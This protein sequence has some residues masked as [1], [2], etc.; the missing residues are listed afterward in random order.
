LEALSKLNRLSAIGATS[1]KEY[2]E[3]DT[4]VKSNNINSKNKKIIDELLA[5]E[6]KYPQYRIISLSKVVELM[7]KYNLCLGVLSKYEETIPEVNQ[8]NIYDYIKLNVPKVS[9][10]SEENLGRILMGGTGDL[11][12]GLL[13]VAPKKFFSKDLVEQNG[14]MLGK[15]DKP[16]FSFKVD[17]TLK[18]TDPIVLSQLRIEHYESTEPYFHIV[19][20]WDVEANDPNVSK[21]I[22]VQAGKN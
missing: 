6:A 22:P 9:K 14:F 11:G 5:F 2:H 12:E 16:K 15:L 3:A 8:N 21:H 18:P 13:M 4:I 7:G 17:Y 20:A 19:D 1:S 10:H